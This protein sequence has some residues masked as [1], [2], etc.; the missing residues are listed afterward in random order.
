M[1][2]NKNALQMLQHP[3]GI[4]IYVVNCCNNSK[5]K[6]MDDEIRNTFNKK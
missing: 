1:I 2:N 4:N 6:I 5:T 3:S